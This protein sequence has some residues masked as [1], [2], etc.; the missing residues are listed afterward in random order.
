V[1]EAATGH[2]DRSLWVA[3]LVRDIVDDLGTRTQFLAY[4]GD[5]PRV[6]TDL[7]LE[8]SE[9]YPKLEVDWDNIRQSLESRQPQTD[10]HGLSD[11]EVVMRFRELAHEQGLSVQDIASRVHIEP[12]NILQETETLVLTEGNRERFEQKS[13]SV[14]AYLAENHPEYAYGVMKV[15]LYLQGD[16]G[17]LEKLVADEPSGF[18]VDAVRRR[19]EHWSS[20]L[21]SHMDASSKSAE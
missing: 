18:S 3:W 2:K 21:L 13:G 4:L 19:K 14:F 20:S 15:R 16:H 11:D 12:R 7:Q 9:L 17:S 10:L 1:P 8:I 6:T 5:R